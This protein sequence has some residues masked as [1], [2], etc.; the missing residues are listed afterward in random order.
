MSI[1]NDFCFS[2]EN[3]SIQKGLY[4]ENGRLK[5]LDGNQK[6]SKSLNNAIFLKDDFNALKKKVNSMYTDPLHIRIED[7]GHVEGMGW[8]R[9]SGR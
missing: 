3:L 8:S 4:S 1:R 2:K 7:P 9:R 5:G 6:M